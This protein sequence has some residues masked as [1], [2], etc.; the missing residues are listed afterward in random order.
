AEP[1]V[2]PPREGGP[3]TVQEYDEALRLAQSR[4]ER[5]EQ[6]VA[7]LSNNLAVVS[8]VRELTELPTTPLLSPVTGFSQSGDKPILTLGR[9]GQ[10]NIEPGMTVVWKTAVVGRVLPPVGPTTCRVELV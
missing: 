3:T 4:I 1:P 2:L 5:L 6:Q 9:G 7:E 10:S 8:A